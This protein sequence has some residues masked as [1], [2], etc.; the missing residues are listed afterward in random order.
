M[1]KGASR[2]TIPMIPTS[3]VSSRTS[4]GNRT[5][6]SLRSLFQERSNQSPEVEDFVRKVR[7]KRNML[8]H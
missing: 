3:R 2:K 1:R 4:G 5:E 7:F 6:G 8:G